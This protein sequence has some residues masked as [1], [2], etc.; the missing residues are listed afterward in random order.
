MPNSQQE[1][2]SNGPTYTKLPLLARFYVYGL[3][4]IFTEVIYTSIWDFVTLY[5]W[6]LVGVS[7]TWAFFIYSLSHLFIEYISPTLVNNYKLPLWARAFVYLI[8]T[9]FW[10]FSTGYVLSMF[11]ACPWDYSPWFNWHVMGLITLEYAP[12]WYFGSIFAERCV[13]PTVNRLHYL[14]SNTPRVDVKSE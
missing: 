6:K 14:E 5:S 9:Y 4:G 7:S 3:Q 1:T 2:V 11:N 10:E 8:W 12:L 13:I